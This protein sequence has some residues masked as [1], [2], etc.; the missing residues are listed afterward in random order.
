MTGMKRDKSPEISVVG[1]GS[2]AFIVRVADRRRL[3][4]LHY[5]YRAP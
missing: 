1:A 5:H 3:G 2:T 4:L